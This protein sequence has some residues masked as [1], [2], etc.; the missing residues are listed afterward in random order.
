MAV[1]L[2][3]LKT[4]CRRSKHGER[5]RKQTTDRLDAAILGGSW[6]IGVGLDVSRGTRGVKH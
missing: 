3:V 4:D 5:G 1:N 2:N 6:A